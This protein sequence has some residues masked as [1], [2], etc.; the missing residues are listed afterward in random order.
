MSATINCREFADYFAVPVQNKMSPAYVFEVEGKPFSIEEY[1][2]ND[3]EHV[4]HSRVCWNALFLLQGMYFCIWSHL[5]SLATIANLYWSLK[6]EQGDGVEWAWRRIRDLPSYL[7]NKVN[8]L[9]Q[10]ALFPRHWCLMKLF[11]KTL[12]ILSKFWSVWSLSDDNDDIQSHCW[13]Q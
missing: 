1:Y 2:L 10:H 7:P 9:I 3:L 11:I 4:H 12:K 5:H 13:P 8:Y 6:L